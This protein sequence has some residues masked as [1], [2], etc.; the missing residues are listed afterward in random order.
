VI[1][2]MVTASRARRRVRSISCEVYP[3]KVQFPLR[4]FSE[5]DD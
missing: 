1:N 3:A 5:N 4:H 2:V